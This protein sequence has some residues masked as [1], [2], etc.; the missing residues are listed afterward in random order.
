MNNI[1][2]IYDRRQNSIVFSTAREIEKGEELFINYGKHPENLYQEYG[3]VCNCGGCR[4]LT[5]AEIAELE[6]PVGR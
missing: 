2:Y 5:D 6:N 3:F 4:V 1:A